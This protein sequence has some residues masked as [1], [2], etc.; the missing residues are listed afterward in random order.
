MANKGFNGSTLVFNSVTVGY[1]RGIKYSRRVPKIDVSDADDS[2]GTQVVGIPQKT[3]TVDVIGATLPTATTGA[4]AIVWF[5][6]S[7]TIGSLTNA[8]VGDMDVNGSMNG[9]I[10]GSIEFVNTPS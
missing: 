1:L 5:D 9:E 7:A 4:L 10:T 6:S 8:A 2:D 3:V